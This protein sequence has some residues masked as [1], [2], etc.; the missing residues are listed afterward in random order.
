MRCI[1]DIINRFTP[2][3][4]FEVFDVRNKNLIPAIDKY[5]IFI[6]TGG[7][8]SPLVGD[9]KWDKKFYDFLE[10]ITF[11]NKNKEEKKHLLCICH[12]FQMACLHFGLAEV[13]KRKTTSFGVKKIIK[14]KEGVS[15]PVFESL[16]NPFYAIDSRDYQVIRP[17]Y[18]AF[19][20]KGATIIS[21]ENNK[22]NE[23]SE[24]AIMAVRFSKYFIGTQFHPEANPLIFISHLK[25]KSSKNKI[26]EING[27][28]K[29]RIMLDDIVDEDKI[30]LTNKTTIPNF[31]RLAINNILKTK[32]ILSN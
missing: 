16:K 23:Q 7:P 12:S 8:G 5:D 1:I 29:F 32:K 27:K 4:S 6:A 24:E 19:E 21:L 25:N 18:E 17:K 2:I 9:G 22:D 11:W 14:T 3:I 10:K 15:E 26:K 31:V 20:R 28:K 13:T 30:Y